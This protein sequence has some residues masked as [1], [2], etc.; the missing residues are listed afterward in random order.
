VPAVGSAEPNLLVAWSRPAQL[1]AAALVGAA[2]S[3]LSVHA[4]GFLSLGARP[5]ELREGGLGYRIDLNRASHAE[6]LQLPGVGEKLAKRIEDHRKKHGPFRSADDLRQVKGVG[7]ALLQRLRP[8]VCVGDEDGEDEDAA[9]PPPVPKRAV[10][11]KP[12]KRE[13][14]LKGVIIDVNRASLQE[15]QRLP[16]IGP[17]KSQRIVDA[18]K[19]R[20]FQKVDDLRR[21]SGIGPKTLA[22]LRPYVTVGADQPYVAPH[23][24]TGTAKGSE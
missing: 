15:L 24:G 11:R 13:A 10:A 19:L 14:D 5:T 20:P 21:V 4:S 6:L 7:A 3:F 22:K 17:K 9:E 8:W 2:V 12:G 23:P 1:A 18:R 16:G